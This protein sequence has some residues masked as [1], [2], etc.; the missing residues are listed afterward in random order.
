MAKKNTSYGYI[1]G[2]V[3][4]IKGKAKTGDVSGSL[5]K[6]TVS[7][8]QLD[9][10]LQVDNRTD[11][12]SQGR[13]TNPQL[14]YAY[15]TMVEVEPINPSIAPKMGAPSLF[16]EYAF[17]VHP[18]C[19]T[20]NDFFDI[21]GEDGAFPAHDEITGTEERIDSK[22]N[23]YEVNVGHG[24]RNVTE[25]S[26]IAHAPPYGFVPN[27][28]GDLYSPTPYN[29]SDFIFCKYHRKIPL[30]HQITLRRF[31][32][33][34]FDNLDAD[35][36]QTFKPI[37]QAITYFGEPTGNTLKDLSKF[38]GYINWEEMAADVWDTDGEEVG[39]D[40]TPFFD[41]GNNGKLSKVK[42]AIKY[43]NAIGNQSGD[44][45][46]GR[47]QSQQ[48]QAR[49][50][51]DPSFTNEVLG[52]VNVIDKTNIRARGIGAT[53]DISLTFEYELRSFSSINPR[54]A[55]VDLLCNMLA[56]TFNNAKFWGGAN[57]YF[58]KYQQFGFIGDQE[59]YYSGDYAGYFNSVG[60]QAGSLLG[61]GINLL[62]GLLGSLFSGNF[63]GIADI[64]KGAG[65]S[66]M[67]FQAAKSRPK[68]VGL[69]ALLSGL[70]IGEWHV[71]VGNPY[72]PFMMMG[73]LIVKTFDF[74][75]DGP[76]SADDMPSNLKFVINLGTGRPRDKGDIESIFSMGQGRVYNPQRNV[77]DVQNLS[78]STGSIITPNQSNN[79]AKSKSVNAFGQPVEKIPIF[80]SRGTHDLTFAQKL[81]GT[82]Y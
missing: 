21:K 14:S 52:P 19:D 62:S 45:N 82:L 78:S 81:S 55:L 80:Q 60:Q 6:P 47:Y 53:S 2:Q 49:L 20:A 65:R 36:N 61:K 79:I 35:G 70:P 51:K 34:T 41:K 33:P 25:E 76:M 13:A 42:N 17:V 29:A 48:D 11:F 66:I 15:A 7:K 59:K 77:A 68:V 74:D 32:F 58:P 72:R 27:G 57:R 22:G 10:G 24:G 67:D 64:A 43:G 23:V 26:L 50:L 75:F 16:S 4:K 8:Q 18:K 56:L 63:G 9:T 1:A 46:S 39:T 69:R 12:A 73:N 5:T 54:L 30:N 71:T 3:P 37:A 31:P 28:K 44:Q 40:Q 38:S